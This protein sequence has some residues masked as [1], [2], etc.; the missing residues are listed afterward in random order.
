M[1]T[2]DANNAYRGMIAFLIDAWLSAQTGSL[3]RMKHAMTEIQKILMDVL[4]HVRL[5]L[6]GIVILYVCQFVVTA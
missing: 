1:I 2:Q 6:D 3:M 5:K 4:L